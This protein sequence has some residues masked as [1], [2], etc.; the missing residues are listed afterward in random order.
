MADFFPAL[1]LDFMACN[2]YVPV[3]R[4]ALIIPF[5]VQIKWLKILLEDIENKSTVVNLQKDHL[6]FGSTHQVWDSL[7]STVSDVKKRIIKAHLLTG[8]YMLQAMDEFD[9]IQC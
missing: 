5:F 9:N 4:R 7:Q 6:K 2:M 8:I 3:R 1:Y